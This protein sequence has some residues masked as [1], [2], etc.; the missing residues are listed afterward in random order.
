[1]KPLTGMPNKLLMHFRQNAGKVLSRDELAREVW[2]LKMDPRSRCID[3]TIATI[4]KALGSG[5]RIETVQGCGYRFSI[6]HDFHR[7]P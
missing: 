5:E 2:G 6:R 1:M 4:R 7:N 3:Q